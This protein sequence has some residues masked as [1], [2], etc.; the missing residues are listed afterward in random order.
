MLGLDSYDFGARWQMPDLTRFG[1]M[2]P[3]AEKTPGVSPYAYCMGNPVRYVDPEGK[4]A[5]SKL[6]K[7]AFKVTK[8]VAKNGVKALGDAATYAD[9]VSDIIEDVNTLTDNNSSGWEKVG[10]VASLASEVF[11]VSVSDAKGISSGIAKL[12]SAKNNV[13]K[14]GHLPNPR[15]FGPGKK[16]TTLQKKKILEENRKMNG[17]VLR[18]DGDGRLL[19]NPSKSEKGVPSDMDQAEID[20]IIPR[21]KGG[22][23]DNQNLQVLSKEEN[24]KKGNR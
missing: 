2:D 10:A 23:N 21:S 19:N 12:F 1:Q 20:H 17:G 6:G 13:G 9:A 5:W 8:A 18:S 15:N 16:A 22:G 4:S 3:L 11:P 24:L 7:A 14:Y